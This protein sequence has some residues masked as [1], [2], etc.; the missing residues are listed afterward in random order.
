MDRVGIAFNSEVEAPIAIDP[1]LP[2]VE[3]IVVFLGVKRWMLEIVFK[4]LNLFEKR[5]AHSARSI[6]QRFKA[7]GR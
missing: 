1:G 3:G 4:K 6:L 5:L 7:R 2:H